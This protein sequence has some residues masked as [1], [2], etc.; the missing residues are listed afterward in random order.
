MPNQ[1][2]TNQGGGSLVDYLGSSG[3][4]ASVG[5]RAKL[6]ESKGLG[7]ASEYLD[8]YNKTQSGEYDNSQE[9]MR[10]LNALRG[11]AFV[12]SK[13]VRDSFATAQNEYGNL[14]A[15]TQ[16]VFKAPDMTTK[17]ND[18]TRSYDD[19]L[20]STLAGFDAMSKRM[21]TSSQNL[22]GS[23]SQTYSQRRA[24]QAESDRK[25]ERGLEVLG[26][27]SGMARYSPQESLGLLNEAEKSAN[28]KLRD[29]DSEETKARIDAENAKATND[30]KTFTDRVNL[31]KDLRQQKAQALKDL[32]DEASRPYKLLKEQTDAME[33]LGGSIYESIQGLS[34]DAK[35]NAVKKIA[36]EFN[37]P[38]Q[39]VV[40]AAS[41]YALK[42]KPSKGTGESK[43][44]SLSDVKNARDLY[45][46]LA[47]KINTG[48]TQDDL[49][50][51]V[52]S[53]T[54]SSSLGTPEHAGEA[55]KMDAKLMSKL[56]EK[57][58][59]TADIIKLQSLLSQGYSLQQIADKTGMPEEVF[60]LLSDNLESGE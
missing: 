60:N 55:L 4:D 50:A 21:D 2:G 45:P 40:S 17:E 11:N 33:G 6:Y 43:R 15:P 7:T 31:I 12:T 20:K 48:M 35:A 29:I 14:N 23:I 34:G 22:L 19:E 49:D 38:I 59:Q 47:D 32:H 39:A 27:K 30:Y 13:P 41:N 58:V 8:K 36:D 3:Q 51:L 52:S 44:L 28:K 57:G 37:V 1:T 54:G 9:N 53:G 10:L 42:L 18:I 5:N 56:E 25:Y 26:I 46:N 16:Q 24:D